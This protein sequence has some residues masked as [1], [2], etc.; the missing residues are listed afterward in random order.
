MELEVTLLAPR[1][2]AV[3]FRFL[4][5]KKVSTPASTVCHQQENCRVISFVWLVWLHILYVSEDVVKFK[6]G[7]FLLLRVIIL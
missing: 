5:G 4:G 7:V 3:A 6:S 2:F 1:I